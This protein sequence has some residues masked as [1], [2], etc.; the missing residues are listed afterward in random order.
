MKHGLALMLFAPGIAT[1]TLLLMGMAPEN[2]KK[3]YKWV[4]H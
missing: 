1:A 4:T 2:T 3:L